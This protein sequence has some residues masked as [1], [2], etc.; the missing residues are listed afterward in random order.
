MTSPAVTLSGSAIDTIFSGATY[1]DSGASWTDNVDGTGDILTFNSGT[2]NTSV[3]GSYIVEYFY[4]DAAGN[5]GSVTRTINVIEP[6]VTAPVITLNGT[7]PETIAHGSTYTDLGATWTDNV[8]GTGTIS[9]FNSGTLD[10][11][12]VGSYIVEY[13]YV[14]GAGNTGSV[15]RTIN[16][17]DQTAPVVSLNG[18][19]I[20]S[21]NIGTNYI[22]AGA[23]WLDNVDGSG[24]VV[25]SG[26]VN[27]GALGTYILTYTKTDAAGNTSSIT[28]TV[29]IIDA[30][31]PVI[32]L[33]G[34]GNITVNIG[35][36][37]IDA[38]ASWIDNVDGSG[39]LV[40]SGT[41]NT[42]ALGTYI[43]TYIMTDAA[44]NI[45]TPV[46]RTVTIASGALPVITL[47]G[48]GT[49]TI[50]Q[51]A[52]YMNPGATAFDAEDGVIPVTSGS[53]TLMVRVTDPV[54]PAAST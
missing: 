15:T 6:D 41:V 19:G 42:G 30:I 39:T 34:S 10:T 27:T 33:I 53:M 26:T 36:G 45:A 23:N 7:T 38:G 8:D 12:S 40:A 50:S 31:A 29:N 51:G 14:D 46:T 43:L 47:V 18:I 28:R 54:F 25:A 16:V 13:F 24:T 49:Q 9:A 3:T 32:T 11:N 21:L 44:G 1:T 48:S 35:S 5:T 2:L 4:V 22:D 20:I 52:T 17:T 37:Y